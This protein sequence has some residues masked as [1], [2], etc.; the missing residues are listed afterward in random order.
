MHP[1]FRRNFLHRG[2]KIRVSSCR[3]AEIRHR[4]RRVRTLQ[5]QLGEGGICAQ[6]ARQNSDTNV[7]NEV[8]CE[9]G[10]GSGHEKEPGH[11]IRIVLRRWRTVSGDRKDCRAVRTASKPSSAIMQ[12]AG[13]EGMKSGGAQAQRGRWHLADRRH[14]A[15]PGALAACAAWRTLTLWTILPL[16]A[17]G[18]APRQAAG[19]TQAPA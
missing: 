17:P 9:A 3:G 14:P 18:A 12:P 1:R 13:G 15:H 2:A 7:T 16:S 8:I 11:W 4:F 6:I 5:V 19:A 10:G